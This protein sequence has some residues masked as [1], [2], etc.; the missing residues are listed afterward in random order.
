LG[1]FLRKNRFLVPLLREIPEK[2][3]DYFGKEQKLSLKI[4]FESDSLQLAELWVSILTEL[5]AN[6]VLPILDRFD[7]EWW[8]E[9][10][11]RADSKL[12]ITLKFI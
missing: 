1:S 6:E 8:L 11:N 7:E 5:L 4:S 3:Y 9:N 10:M 12:N 2:I